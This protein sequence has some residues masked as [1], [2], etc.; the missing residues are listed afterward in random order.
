MLMRRGDVVLDEHF[1]L[2]ARSFRIFV[3]ETVSLVEASS[4]CNN[5]FFSFKD[6][7]LVL[8]NID[9]GLCSLLYPRIADLQPHKQSLYYTAMNKRLSI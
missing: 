5:L 6:F 2:L 7:S 9:D 8:S 4:H 1:I 3:L